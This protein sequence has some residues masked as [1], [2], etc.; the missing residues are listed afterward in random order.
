MHKHLDKGRVGTVPLGINKNTVLLEEVCKNLPHV[1]ICLRGKFKGETG[2]D[3]HLITV[4]NE[5]SS[6]LL[7]W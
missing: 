7:P 1:T 4:A 3:Q 5:M 6:G 2:V